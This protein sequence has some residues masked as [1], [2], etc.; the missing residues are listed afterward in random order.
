M[1][2]LVVLAII[3]L[4]AGV[5]IPAVSAGMDSVRLATATESIASFL[6]GAVNRAER[7]QQPVELVISPKDNRLTLYTTAPAF[8]RELK[9][10]EGITLEAVLP[11]S[12][13]EEGVR[14]IILMPGGTAPAGWPARRRAAGALGRMTASK[15]AR[16][17]PARTSAS[18][19]LRYGTS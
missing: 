18:L 11:R 2:L 14:R 8:T 16:R 3:G 15:S 9:M 5:S 1:E 7:R 19:R 4:M 13:D 17:L 10:P 12:P 6:N